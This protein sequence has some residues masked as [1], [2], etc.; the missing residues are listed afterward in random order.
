MAF[1]DNLLYQ[2]LH[3]ILWLYT[4]VLRT[5]PN[6]LMKPN[7]LRNQYP[8]RKRSIR[9]CLEES[10]SLHKIP[11]HL[12][13]VFV[14]D[15]VSLPDVANIVVWCAAVG[16]SYISVYDN[17]GWLHGHSEDL[18][19]FISEKEKQL[20]EADNLMFTVQTVSNS[21]KVKSSANGC[22]GWFHK[23]SKCCKLYILEPQD[24]QPNLVRAAKQY[25]SEP[26]QLKCDRTLKDFDLSDILQETHNFPDPELILKFGTVSSLLG[27]L[28]WQIRLTEIISHPSHHGFDCMSLLHLLH[29]FARTEQRF[30]K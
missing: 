1:I 10:K 28:P 23:T 26:S 29:L 4:L 20:L 9:K 2:F 18:S 7:V 16:I 11:H 13:L 25:C 3:L 17:Q 24:G 8:H 30:G 27:Y 12:G 19:K 21:S 5:W 15:K 14:E 6:W 22:S